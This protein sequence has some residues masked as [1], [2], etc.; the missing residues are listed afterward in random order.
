MAR[1]LLRDYLT[2]GTGN[3]TAPYVGAYLASIFMRRVLGYSYVGDTRF[4][5][6]SVGSLLISTADSTPTSTPTFAVSTKAGVGYSGTGKEFNVTI[7]S[8][9]RVVGAGD[10]G[11][12]L[13]LQSTTN[14]TFNSGCFLITG[15]DSGTNSYVVD[16]RSGTYLSGATTMTAA[17]T[18]PTGTLNVVSTT[19]F[20]SSGSILVVSSAGTQTVNYTSTNSTQFLGCTGGTGTLSVGSPINLQVSLPAATLNV[21]STSTT[22]F[23]SSGTL[24]V[25]SSAGRQSVTYTGITA[26][27]FTGCSGGTGTIVSGVADGNGKFA[28]PFV[29]PITTTIAAGSNGQTLPFATI[30]VASTLIASTTITSGSNNVALPTG[31]INVNSTTGFPTSGWIYVTTGT[32][33]Q[34]VTYTG[35]T[36]TTFTG[37]TGGSGFMATGNAVA[38]GFNPNGGIVYVTT[39]AGIQRVNYNG[40]TPTTFIGCSGGT[41]TMSTGGAVYYSPMIPVV[42]QTDSMNWYLYEADTLGPQIGNQNLVSPSFSVT[43]ETGT[44]GSVYHVTVSSS[45]QFVNGQRV[46]IAGVTGTSNSSNSTWT[47]TVTG[48]N[49]FDLNGSSW[50]AA[51]TYTGGG[52]VTIPDV[53]L[54]ATLFVNSATNYSTALTN[55][56]VHSSSGIQ[57]CTWSGTAT[58]AGGKVAL[59]GISGGVGTVSIGNAIYDN[60]SNGNTTSQ[61]RG[62]GT[63]TAPRIILQSPHPMGWQVRICHEAVDDN[64]A[65]ASSQAAE[66]PMISMSPGLG[67]NASGDFLVGGQHIHAP[68]YL[69]SNNTNLQGGAPGFGDNLNFPN[70][71]SAE[72]YR[73]TMAGDTDGYGLVIIGRR[74]GNATGPRSYLMTFGMCESETLPLPPNNEARLFAIGSGNSQSSGNNLNDVSW[75]PGNIGTGGTAQGMTQS[76]AFGSIA[77]PSTICSSFLTYAT[78]SGSFGSPIFDG[79]AGDTPWFGGVELFPI[80]IISG[81][82]NTWNNSAVTN[83]G[84]PLTQGRFLGTIPHIREGRANFQEYAV[85]ADLVGQHMRRGL[86]MLWGGPPV[87]P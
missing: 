72:P 50:G 22:H 71:T 47:I 25:Y 37:C 60:T 55:L 13:V 83:Y 31:T 6:N 67:G 12:I 84:F 62:Y 56:Y 61:Y 78:G 33:P 14:P 28:S 42:E 26:T 1:H 57:K 44:T 87:V 10:V 79:S 73:I 40:T 70:G 32:T 18:L 46:T 43:N 48:S 23:P 36:A 9:T 38:A 58:S 15:F 7:P 49:T 19:G 74:P 8:G 4:P 65:T 20:P 29:Y 69:N 82:V 16:F 5:I 85:T 41:G 52:T 75:F 63:S 54:P 34:L 24:W 27:S 30:N 45:H 17:P 68:F 2:P 77:V 66:C 11:R 64:G 76:P 3:F 53:V 80:D 86:W 81:I 51:T 35:T 21:I 59:T 39:S